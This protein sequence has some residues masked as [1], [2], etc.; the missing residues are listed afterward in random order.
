MQKLLRSVFL[1]FP[2]LLLSGC[3]KPP[4]KASSSRPADEK[5]ASADTASVRS[6]TARRITPGGETAV[7][8]H[9]V[10]LNEP[11]GYKLRVRW[12]RGQMRP[13]KA[14]VVPSFDDPNSFTLAVQDGVIAL[15]LADVAAVLNGGGLKGTPLS[16]VS[17]ADQ[18]QQLKLN[19]T[20]H[21]GL[22]LP[23]EMISDVRATPDGRIDLHATKLRVLKLPVTGLLKSLKVNLSDL[24]DS[25]GA[26]G[27]QISGDDIY[28]NP[29]QF[30]PAPHIQGK[31]TDVH[32]GSKTGDLI[33]V[34]GTA[35][36]DVV[37][38]KEWR[39]FIR[40]RGGTVNFGKLTMNYS[41]LFL[42]DIS[43]DEWFNFDLARYQEQLVNGRIQMTPEAGL[44]IF[45]PG[46]DK[47]PSNAANRTI[48]LQWLKNRNLPPPATTE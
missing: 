41:D 24:V 9:N 46:I 15:S 4:Q 13:T 43:N 5:P 40:L 10:I 8:I 33:S 14:G 23:I 19:G 17:L 18:G 29:E 45:M 44:R 35:R 32:L 27:I 34:F 12:L 26:T 11:P 42:I 22:P 38:V 25:K 47:I 31:L 7:L 1:L 6:D 3:A 28:I 39:N 36:A 16:N 21:K 2:I 48:S 37:K 20:L 30:L